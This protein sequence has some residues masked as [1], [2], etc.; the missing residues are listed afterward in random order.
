[1]TTTMTNNIIAFNNSSFYSEDGVTI[2]AYGLN[3]NEMGD[4]EINSVID[5]VLI[6]NTIVDDDIAF[7]TQRTNDNISALIVNTIIDGKL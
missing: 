3:L 4:N 5:A 7:L 1:M 6:N 2:E